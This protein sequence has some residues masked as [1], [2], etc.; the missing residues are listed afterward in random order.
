MSTPQLQ[1]ATRILN[2]PTIIIRGGC[3]RTTDPRS[4]WSTYSGV[5]TIQNRVTGFRT[6]LAGRS[7]R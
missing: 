6:S 3:S 2:Q 1:F 4:T 7:S 5:L